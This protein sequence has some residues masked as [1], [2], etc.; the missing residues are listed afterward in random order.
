MHKIFIALGLIL[1]LIGLMILTGGC[2]DQNPESTLIP[3]G[4]ELSATKPDVSDCAAYHNLEVDRLLLLN[5]RNEFLGNNLKRDYQATLK[6][7]ALRDPLMAT[8]AEQI[9]QS[10]KVLVTLLQIQQERHQPIEIIRIMKGAFDDFTNRSKTNSEVVGKLEEALT[11]LI[12]QDQ[13]LLGEKLN[14][15]KILTD[16]IG[17]PE[18]IGVVGVFLGSLERSTNKQRSGTDYPWWWRW[19]VFNDVVGTFS[20]GP[21]VGAY[22]SAMAEL[23]YQDLFPPG[24][25]P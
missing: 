1:S 24:Y 20:G 7:M 22:F 14:H 23:I 16:R 6:E 15:L 25:H 13:Q 17:T 18:E 19:V 4:I 5:K 21:Q 10:W 8:S 2:T 11:L 9:E 12:S 3:T